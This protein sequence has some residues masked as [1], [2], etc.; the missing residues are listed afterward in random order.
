LEEA[1]WRVWRSRPA[2]LRSMWLQARRAATSVRAFWMAV[3]SSRLS[4][5]K[6]S[7]WMTVGMSS[8][9]WW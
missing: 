9:R 2:R 8:E 3:R 7:F 5:R 4:M 1:I 6:G